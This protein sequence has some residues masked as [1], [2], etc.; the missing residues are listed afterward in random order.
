MRAYYIILLALFLNSI[1]GLDILDSIEDQNG[2]ITLNSKFC[3]LHKDYLEFRASHEMIEVVNSN[4]LHKCTKL[5]VIDLSMNK[6]SYLASETFQFNTAVESLY[7]Q[8][9]Q[10]TSVTR[11]LFQP[12]KN[13]ELLSLSKNPLGTIDPI[14]QS[15]LRSLKHLFIEDIR[16][17]ELNAESVKQK[18]PRL[19]EISFAYNYLECD[20][21]KQLEG[22]FTARKVK[23]SKNENG[24][25]CLTEV[26]VMKVYLTTRDIPQKYVDKI[27][28]FQNSPPT[29]I[30][31]NH[32]AKLDEAKNAKIVQNEDFKSF[33]AGF[34]SNMTQPSEELSAKVTQKLIKTIVG[35][36]LILLIVLVCIN[37]FTIKL[38]KKLMQKPSVD[39]NNLIEL[40]TEEEEKSNK[41]NEN[42]NNAG[43][44]YY[45]L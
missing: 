8:N 24:E 14:L 29:S 23:L 18:L 36:F 28:N 32:E 10:L 41:A 26:E 27:L 33:I 3:D 38:I 4:T 2:K 15:S 42:V 1:A 13:L 21:Y 35:C 6:I 45:E 30:V 19:I 12:L 16:I 25:K 31:K 11:E 17:F 22:E 39:Y 9:N 40:R 5:E 7:L 34:F 43:N 20:R 37:M 44:N